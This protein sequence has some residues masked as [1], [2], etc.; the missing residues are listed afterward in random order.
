MRVWSLICLA[1]LLAVSSLSAQAYRLQFKDTAGAT[2]TYKTQVNIAG[3]VLMGSISSPLDSTMSMTA[4][5][6]VTGITDGKSA[7]TYQIKDGTVS[8]KVTVPGEEAP[9]TLEQ[10]LPEFS[11]FYDRTMLGQVSNLRT[12]GEAAGIMGGPANSANNQFI[13]PGEGLVLP[14]KELK[15]GD[16][17][18]RKESLPMN[19]DSKLDVTANYTLVGPKV[20]ENGKTY[21]QIDVD[22]TMNL[23][24][25]AMKAGG[26]GDQAINM[27][28]SMN[29]KGKE[30]VLFDE[31]A[32][33]L[34]RV[35]FKMSGVT[36][37]AM[38]GQE[39]DPM[40]MTMNTTAVMTKVE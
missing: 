31:Q 2:R 30:T 9:Q 38:P 26:E 27:T 13:N 23:P 24:K 21:L 14:D 32:G 33:E 35:S 17:W 37:M 7:I 19:A 4:V 39:G 11:M 1:T 3:S 28:M 34:Y 20:A 40:K 25:M 29:M 12:S 5:E 16:R 22:L 8:V 18:S 6:K 36:N 15:V 10:Q